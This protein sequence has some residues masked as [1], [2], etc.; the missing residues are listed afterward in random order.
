MNWNNLRCVIEPIA[1][2]D[3]GGFR[4]YYPA[5]GH[6][7]IGHGYD[8]FAALTDLV[9][10]HESYVKALTDF[11]LEPETETAKFLQ[12]NPEL[13]QAANTLATALQEF[14]GKGTVEVGVLVD[15]DGG[16]DQVALEVYTPL[17][18]RELMRESRERLIAQIVTKPNRDAKPVV[19]GVHQVQHPRSNYEDFSYPLPEHLG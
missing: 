13:T 19:S 17:P 5:L 2:E 7:L 4:A 15:P 11:E 3:G 18:G 8:R 10:G 9:A 1:P 12:E 6:G 16:E 14:Y